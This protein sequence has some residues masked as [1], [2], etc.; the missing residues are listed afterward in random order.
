MGRIIR[1]GKIPP[2]PTRIRMGQRLRARRIELGLSQGALYEAS[3]VTA[4]YISAIENAEVNISFDVLERLCK[5][6]DLE[7]YD[8]VRP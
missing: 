3:G 4:S 2:T 8:L 1:L 7:V 5:A 6:L